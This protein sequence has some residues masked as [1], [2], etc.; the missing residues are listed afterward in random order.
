MTTA[1]SDHADVLSGRE[2][3]TT[4]LILAIAGPRRRGR[5]AADALA[6]ARD[7]LGAAGPQ[8]RILG[9]YNHVGSRPGSNNRA[10]VLAV[11]DR[12]PLGPG[13]AEEACRAAL[14]CVRAVRLSGLAAAGGEALAVRVAIAAGS[15]PLRLAD[16]AAGGIDA[17]EAADRLLAAGARYGTAIVIAEEVRRLAGAHIHVRELGRV[18]ARG[19]AGGAIY[20]LVRADRSAGPSWIALYE[21]GLAAYRRGDWADALSFLHMLLAVRGNDR[22]ALLLIARCQRR[23][24]A[25]GRSLTRR[26]SRR[27]SQP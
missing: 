12:M 26:D 21:A 23:L 20:E 13:Q 16:P 19:G 1:I 2:R 27:L 11:W 22:P 6:L 3:R 15:G 4:A 10:R 8:A 18:A 24:T 25:T 14:A 5:R 17:A 9:G 7:A